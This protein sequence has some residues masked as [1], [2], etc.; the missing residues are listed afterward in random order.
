MFFFFPVVVF[1]G[2]TWVK[3]KTGEPDQSLAQSTWRMGVRHDFYSDDSL[4][5]AKD[6]SYFLL[7]E[8][9]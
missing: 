9:L 4:K 5:A 2:A 1:V 6:V 3:G 8:L 7:C